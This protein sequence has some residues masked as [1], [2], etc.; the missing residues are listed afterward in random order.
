MVLAGVS[1]CEETVVLG[2]GADFGEGEPPII[3]PSMNFI[4]GAVV[5]NKDAISRAERGDMALRSR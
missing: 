3:P 4:D 5:W 1:G 2:K